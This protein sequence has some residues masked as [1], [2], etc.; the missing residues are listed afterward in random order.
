ML[1]AIKPSL[2][3]IACAASALMGLAVATAMTIFSWAKR[4]SLAL[5]SGEIIFVLA[6]NVAFGVSFFWLVA[7]AL[8]ELGISQVT[9]DSF[10]RLFASSLCKVSIANAVLAGALGTGTVKI[11][12]LFDHKFR[13]KH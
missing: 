1:Q 12:D 8:G 5:L 10:I 11:V 13:T 9:G 4:P 2:P 6:W 7:L 3:V